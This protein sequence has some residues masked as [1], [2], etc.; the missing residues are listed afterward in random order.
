MTIEP[1]DPATFQLPEQMSTIAGDVDWLYYFIY[2]LS[3]VL[4]VGIVGAMVYFAWKYRARKGHNAEPTGHNLPLELAWTVAPIFILVFL[5]HKGFQGYMD[6][7]VAPANAMVI[8][9]NAKQWGW[10]F[11]YPNGGADNELHVPVHKP[12]KLLMASSDVIHSFFMPALRVKRDV[13]PGLY[14]SQWFEATHV[15][16]DDIVC[17]EYCGGRSKDS[18]GNEL[19]FAQM[20][21][22]WSMH[23]MIH[24]ETEEDFTK[25]LVGIGDP[26]AAYT[27]KGQ[28][29]PN[30]VLVAQGAKIYEKKACIGCHTT[31]GAKLVGPSWKGIWGRQEDT[32]H[33]SIKV[34]E[35]YIRESILQP[36]AKIVAGFPPTMPSFAGQI[37]DDE[38]DEVIAYI[39][40]LK[41]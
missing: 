23:S 29:C 11:V 17:A 4:F 19:P 9:V 36:Q 8:K 33:G 24:V 30:S 3:V 15:G 41:E 38:I 21:G 27:A 25:Y 6:M 13:V 37:S 22:H 10:E 39:K 31:S 26:C 32:D 7:T 14:T 40:S 18:S 35:A 16:T 12:V 2:W 1:N 20:T 34:D 5:F 28:P